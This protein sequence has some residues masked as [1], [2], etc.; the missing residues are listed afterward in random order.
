MD[1]L[2]FIYHV[3]LWTFSATVVF[4]LA[5]IGRK[6]AER[7][8]KYYFPPPAEPPVLGAAHAAGGGGTLHYRS[9]T[10]PPSSQKDEVPDYLAQL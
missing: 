2:Q 5:W 10:E 6:L 1:R 7:K 8:R 9:L 3:L 4:F